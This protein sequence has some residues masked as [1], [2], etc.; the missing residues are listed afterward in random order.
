MWDESQSKADFETELQAVEDA[1]AAKKAALAAKY[2]I[3]PA[4]TTAAMPAHKVTD[5]WPIFMEYG[6]SEPSML[7]SQAAL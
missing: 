1:A 4:N 6:C 2:N 3:V 5:D 7:C